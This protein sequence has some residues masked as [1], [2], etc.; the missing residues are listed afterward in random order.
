M[1]V[2]IPLIITPY[3]SRVLLPEG[4]GKYSFAFSLITYFT[5][6]ASF[7]FETYAQREIARNRD[8]N[9]AKSKT[10]WEI[11]IC[12]LITVAISLVVHLIILFL[13]YDKNIALMQILTIN[14]LAIAFDVAFFFQGNEDFGK[15][16]LRNVILKIIGTASIFIFVKDASDL[17]LYA[18]IN[19]LIIVVSNISLWPTLIRQLQ[20]VAIKTLKP[21]S[22][23]KSAFRLFLPALA[24]TLYTVL[25]K[26]LIGLIAQSDLQN[27]Y[28]EQSEK[29]VKALMVLI[30]CLGAVMIPRNSHEIAQGN[31]DKVK[32]NIYKSFNFVWLLG[33]PMVIGVVLVAHNLIPWFLGTKFNSSILLLQIFAPLI[34][35]IG[36]SNVLGM[37]YMI[38]YKKDK[39]YT[40]SLIIGA[41][42]NFTLNLILIYFY[43]ARG[44][45]IAT[46]IAELCVP[47]IM[48]MFVRKGLSIKSIL[49]TAVKPLISGVIMF[50]CVIP[51][52]LVLE[53]SIINTMIIAI[54]G[55]VVYVVCLLI[56]RE[57]MV[58]E[59]IVMIKN[60]FKKNKNS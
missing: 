21:L 6:F 15:L 54:C 30:T 17:K 43:Q 37:Q 8:D 44:A 42:I 59:A 3:I 39:Q 5:L 45:A 26:T 29:I 34:V 27:G 24:V 28:Y 55:I 41:V 25:D 22:H 2:I 10:F 14:I 13:Y 46:I 38:P 31:H 4:V 40:I 18:L 20:K 56:L 12:R 19:S 35:L 53:S 11:I 9:Q 50:I 16:I 47:L 60:K 48:F 49:K 7:G 58:Y 36:I 51:L 32:Q 33:I 1:L 23:F 52:T 57:K